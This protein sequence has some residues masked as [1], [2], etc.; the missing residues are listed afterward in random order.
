MQISTLLRLTRCLR[1]HIESTSKGIVGGFELTVD[2]RNL[3]E[4]HERPQTVCL[5]VLKV[6]NKSRFDSYS[7]RNSLLIIPHITFRDCRV[8]IFLTT[9]LEIAVC[10]QLVIL[11][12]TLPIDIN[13]RTRSAL[14]L[15]LETKEFF[16]PLITK[17]NNKT[18]VCIY[19]DVSYLSS[20]LTLYNQTLFFENLQN[21]G[22]IIKCATGLRISMYMPI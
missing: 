12:L 13:L 16:V 7:V 17:L 15:E 20:Y 19:I 14:V 11:T 22:T 6:G 10:V 5:R 1:R 4:W 8:H 21:H 3:K 2:Q 18:D 9:F